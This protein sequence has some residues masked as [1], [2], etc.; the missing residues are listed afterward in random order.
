MDAFKRDVVRLARDDLHLDR[1]RAGFAS[2]DAHG[3][4]H[5]CQ[6]V[7]GRGGAAAS[8]DYPHDFVGLGWHAEPGTNW[9]AQVVGRKR[10]DLMDPK[11]SALMMPFLETTTVFRTTD[12]ARMNELHYRLPLRT[13]DLEAGDL[14]FN[15]DWWWHRTSAHPGL[16]VSVPMREVFPRRVFRNNPLFTMAIARFYLL[17]IGVN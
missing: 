5:G 6:I 13:V 3:N 7:A 15:P 14:L 4:L 8:S 11:D 12:M 16:S 9:F 17:S 1:V 10:W 2:E